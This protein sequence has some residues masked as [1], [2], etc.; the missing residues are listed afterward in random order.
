MCRRCRQKIRVPKVLTPELEV[1]PE[2]QVS[3]DGKWTVDASHAAAEKPH[4][5][6]DTWTPAMSDTP[7][8]PIAPRSAASPSV[9]P[10]V[11]MPAMPPSPLPPAPQYPMP[12]AP[13]PSPGPGQYPMPS[14]GYVPPP[15]YMPA[16]PTPPPMP[17]PGG[18]YPPPPG[19]PGYPPPP[20]YPPPNGYGAPP[21]PSYGYAAPPAPAP[22]TP[23]PRV[24]PVRRE[25]SGSGAGKFAFIVMMGLLGTVAALVVAYKYVIPF[26]QEQARLKALEASLQAPEFDF[27]AVEPTNAP[28]AASETTIPEYPELTAR[29]PAEWTELYKRRTAAVEEGLTGTIRRSILGL[30]AHVAESKRIQGRWSKGDIA[31]SWT[32]NGYDVEMVLLGPDKKLGTADDYKFRFKVSRSDAK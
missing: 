22:T 6:R 10:P 21:A 26:Q 3:A 24:V 13:Y 14:G 23:A 1:Q 29:Y 16:A 11:H 19:P 9:P 7:S 25:A 2:T 15:P 12:T 5:H 4:S 17:M 32:I 31:A 8:Q 30:P 18:Y 28:L 20:S 27:N